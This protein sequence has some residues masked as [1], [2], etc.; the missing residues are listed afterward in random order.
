MNV[1]FEC[2][3]EIMKK[4][5][6]AGIHSCYH[7]F[8]DMSGDALV[9]MIAI[10]MAFILEFLEIKNTNQVDKSSDKTLKMMLMEFYR[11]LTPFQ[12][13]VLPDVDIN[14]CDHLLDFLY[15]MT[16]PNNKELR[17]M[18][19]KIDVE[20]EDVTE[21]MEKDEDTNKETIKTFQENHFRPMVLLMK[22]PWKIISNIP[23]LV[24]M[25]EPIER[26]LNTF[27]GEEDQEIQ[28]E[29]CELKTPTIEEITILSIT[30][31]ANARIVISLVYGGILDIRPLVV[32]HYTELMNG[33]VD[34][35]E[36]AKYLRELG[37]VLNRLKSDKEVTDLWNG[38]C[39]SVKLTKVAKMDKVIEDVNKSHAVINRTTIVL[40]GVQ[41]CSFV[42]R[43]T[44]FPMRN[45]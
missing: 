42:L 39:K 43:A 10:D 18:D 30:E 28:E 24:L 16:V 41:L 40:F 17:I 1:S 38:M 6:E 33:I 20:Q 35:E 19:T 21:I 2:V 15:H 14:N 11:E 5:D 13:K 32:A 26:M 27:K 4:N 45:N 7:K 25:K 12:E 36:D 34:T 37:I 23:L 44:R 9:W 22:L 31:M 3:V 29:D 8:L